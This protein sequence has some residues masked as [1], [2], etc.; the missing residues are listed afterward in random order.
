M[1]EAGTTAGG[2][3]GAAGLEDRESSMP[4]ALSQAAVVAEPGATLPLSSLLTVSGTDLPEYLVLVGLDR[5]RYTAAGTGSQG[6]LAG[7]GQTAAFKQVEGTDTAAFGIV[8]TYGASGYANATYGKLLD[9]SFQASAD[10]YRSEL[11]TLYGFG[12]AGTPDAALLAQLQAEVASPQFKG[13]VFMTTAPAAGKAVAYTPDQVLGTLDIVVRAGF[14]DTTPDHATPNEMIAVAATMVGE[15]WNTDGCWVLA[16]NIAAAA[17]ASLPLTSDEA[18]P[19]LVT[20]VANGQWIVAY[21][22]TKVTPQQQMNWESRLRPGDVIVANNSCGGHVATV[23]SGFSW[24]SNIFD[25][26][27]PSAGDGSAADIVIE[28]EHSLLPMIIGSDPGRV[29]IYRL[30]TPVVTTLSPLCID[31]GESHTLAGL[32][33]VADPAGREIVAYQVYNE[34]G[35]Y[36]NGRLLVD[37]VAQDDASPEQPVTVAADQLASVAFTADRSLPGDTVWVRAYNG[38]WWGDWQAIPVS[39]GSSVQAPVVHASSDT[40]RVHGG[41]SV[42]LS[43][44]FSITSPDSPVSSVTVESQDQG[45]SVQLNGAVDLREAK[46]LVHSDHIVEVSLADFGKLSYVGGTT[47]GGEMLSVTAHNAAT[48]ASMPAQVAMATVAPTVQGISHW[49]STGAEVPLSSLFSTTLLD[50]TPVQSYTISINTVVISWG[51]N[52]PSHGGTLS[53]NGATNLL[54]GSG[55]PVGNWQIAAADL[56][57]VTFRAAPDVG[58]QL[59]EIWAS[60]GAGGVPGT[61]MLQT[62]ETPAQ[63]TSLSP[64]AQANHAIGMDQVFSLAPDADAPTF[65]RFIDPI[66][67]GHLQL[68]REANNLI[69]INDLTPGLFVIR[70]GDLGKLSYVGGDVNGSESISVSTT[71]DQL[72]WSPEVPVGVTTDGVVTGTEHDDVLLGA[73]ADDSFDGGAGRDT[74]MLPGPRSQYAL[75]RSGDGW[76]FSDRSGEHGTNTLVGV[77]RLQFSDTSLA[78]DT[79]GSAGTLAR[80]V[81]AVFGSAGLADSGLMGQFFDLLDG[82]MS[83]AGLVSMAIDSDAFIALAGSVSNDD[84]VRTLYR[85]VIGVDPADAE[86]GY[87]VGLIESGATTPAGL[88][89]MAAEVSYNVEKVDLI[90]LDAT[91]VE[92]LPVG[93]G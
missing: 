1:S 33:S 24:A 78:L 3:V 90:G 88:A 17:G 40:V 80:V 47:I 45:G 83:E 76:T 89:L 14:E 85:N 69:G 50:D 35:P 91:G 27:G 30:D 62:V 7:S 32:I 20:P 2:S 22:S 25:N 87:F 75:S 64:T 19:E 5:D 74:V 29:V 67:G 16:N 13:N 39:V 52:V 71:T 66:G 10:E 18:H 28:G 21:D 51:A 59:I 8:F 57:R 86:R 63:V 55:A 23:V 34:S 54:A 36:T 84:L 77:E 56:G 41:Q 42:P 9:M 68:S 93:L 12:T 26:S 79:D 82:G 15:V 92:Y 46:G 60:D 4:I 43:T 11:L 38:D 61:V 48:A 81:H 70:A 58:A 72:V 37:G 44:L 31:S 65:Y 53:L 6:S 49:V 73:S